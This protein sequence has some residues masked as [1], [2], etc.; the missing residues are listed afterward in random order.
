MRLPILS[1]SLLAVALVW[2]GLAAAPAAAAEDYQPAVGDEVVVYT[3]R[4]KPENYDEGLALVRDGFTAAQ[5]EA[6]QTRRNY[7]IVNPT[8]FEV[9]VISY[10]AGGSDVDAWHRFMGRLDV[11][12]K[13]APM[14][15]EPIEIRRYTLEGITTAP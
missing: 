4:F 15:S 8:T 1:L 5:A 12:D 14:R 7:F 13:L 3:H 9:M 10:F 6:G 2:A 11:L